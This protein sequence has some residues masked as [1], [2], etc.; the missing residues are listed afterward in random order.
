MS[1]LVE[2]MLA[3]ALAIVGV[4][5]LAVLVAPNAQTGN[6]LTSGGGAFA[7]MLG[8]AEKPVTGGSTGS[9]SLPSIGGIGF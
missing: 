9:F 6:V 3:I 7:T 5:T 2:A 8:A 1:S 4:A